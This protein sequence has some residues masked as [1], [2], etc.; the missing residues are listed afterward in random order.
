MHSINPPQDVTKSA[1]HLIYMGF[2]DEF[3]P[4]N[5]SF[6]KAN[7]AKKA[8]SFSRFPSALQLI[9]QLRRAA[10]DQI[11]FA[12][13]CNNSAHLLTCWV[14]WWNLMSESH[15]QNWNGIV[16]WS[17]QN[18]RHSAVFQGGNRHTQEIR[19]WTKFRRTSTSWGVY[20][21]ARLRCTIGWWQG[22]SGWSN[23]NLTDM[24]CFWVTIKA[25]HRLTWGDCSM[26]KILFFKDGHLN[27]VHVLWNNLCQDT[28][29]GVIQSI[30][31]QVFQEGK[32]HCGYKTEML[33]IGEQQKV[34][35]T[36]THLMSFQGKNNT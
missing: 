18:L 9:H 15:P 21:S 24:H 36:T 3:L 34:Y 33:C 19:Q 30:L 7:Q 5:L 16:L 10:K 1:I 4:L 29:S 8:V 28:W 32:V 13:W 31:S 35:P 17:M 12:V 26:A 6:F 11:E 2:L 23:C 25:G 27:K 14:L 22:E 20:N